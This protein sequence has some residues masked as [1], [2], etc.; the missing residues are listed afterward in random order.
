M[1]VQFDDIKAGHKMKG[2]DFSLFFTETNCI[3][4]DYLV[5]GSFVSLHP[6]FL[7]WDI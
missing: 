5:I 2:I 1:M 4:S 7:E 6:M 3:A